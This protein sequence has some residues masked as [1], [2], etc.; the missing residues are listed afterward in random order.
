VY[1]HLLIHTPVLLSAADD[2]RLAS[3]ALPVV[4]AVETWPSSIPTTH[5]LNAKPINESRA[6]SSG[7]VYVGAYRAD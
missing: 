4:Q 2:H 3:I 5:R 6:T 7:S 1:R